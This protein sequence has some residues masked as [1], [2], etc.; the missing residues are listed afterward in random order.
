MRLY[1]KPAELLLR[2][3]ESGEYVLE[4]NGE[5][6][7]TFKSE[8]R[9]LA[10]YNRIRRELEKKLPPIDVGAAEREKL[11]KYYIGDNLVKHNSL[12]DGPAKKPAKSRTF[13]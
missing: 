8:K 4:L 9:A 2:Q 7:A 12:R 11:L 1:F 13:G 3:K 6:S 5:L 10:E